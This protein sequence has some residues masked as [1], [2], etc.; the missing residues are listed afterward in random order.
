[1]VS[2]EV[3]PILDWAWAIMLWAIDWIWIFCLALGAFIIW[4]GTINK[5]DDIVK[6]KKKR[7]SRT[8]E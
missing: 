5:A 2:I 7:V 1:M 8:K 4:R 6:G 3:A